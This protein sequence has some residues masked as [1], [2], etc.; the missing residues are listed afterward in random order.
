MHTHTHTHAHAHTH[1]HAP[2][3]R[4]K[5]CSCWAEM[6]HAFDTSTTRGQKQADLFEFQA[7]LVYTESFG[8]GQGYTEKPQL[9]KTKQKT[10]TLN[11]QGNN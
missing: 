10:K 7:N 9:E 5:V 3:V 11:P 6:A 8:A 1:T 2:A 4:E